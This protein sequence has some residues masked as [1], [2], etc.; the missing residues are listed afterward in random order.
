MQ[1]KNPPKKPRNYSKHLIGC[2]QESPKSNWLEH[3]AISF[4]ATNCAEMMHL[5]F[6]L[7][8]CKKDSVAAVIHLVVWQTHVFIG[9]VQLFDHL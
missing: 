3:F 2:I 6:I 9:F 5:I 1:Q 4:G 7:V 8:L